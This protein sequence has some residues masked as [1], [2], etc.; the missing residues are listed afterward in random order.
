MKHQRS[1]GLRVLT[2]LALGFAAFLPEATSLAQSDIADKEN[3][4]FFEKRIRPVLVDKCYKCHAADAEKVKGGLL[5]DT[6]KGLR[7]RGDTG[8]ALIP[9]SPGKSLLMTAIRHADPDTK[10]PPKEKLPD[11][12]IEDFKQWI[13]MGAPDPREGESAAPGMDLE[14]GRKWW[15]LQPVKAPAIPS[16]KDA[17]W[18]R[19]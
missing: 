13:A 6:R 8:P 1:A 11:A 4:D 10:M 17:E 2:R 19:S 5:L 15:S 3:L 7:Q 9:G 12:V 16:V 18:P 14:E